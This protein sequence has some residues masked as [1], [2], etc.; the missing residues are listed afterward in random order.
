MSRCDLHLHSKF[1]DRSE[2]WIFRRFDFPD[3]YSDP[4]ELYRRA[5]AAGMDFVTITDHDTIE[6]CLAISRIV[7]I[8]LL[9]SRLR[10][11]FR[12][13]HAKLICSSG[14]F[15]RRNTPRSARLRD[16]IFDLQAF[17]QTES[18]AH[19]VAHPLYSINGKLSTSH[20][21]RLI[22]L[23][24]HFEG[25][26]R[27]AR[28]A[29]ER[30]HRSTFLPSSRRE[31]IAEF[32][33]RHD[34]R[35]PIPSR[36]KKSSSAART[37]TAGSLLAQPSPKR[38]PRERRTIFSTTSGP[39]AAARTAKGGTP[40]ALS[41]GFYNTLSLFHPGPLHREARTERRPGGKNVFAFHGGA[42]PDRV[43]PRG[44]SRLHHAGR[45]FRQNLR[46]RET[47]EH[48]A[49]ARALELLR[50]AGSESED[51]RAKSRRSPNPSVAR[52]SWPT[53]PASS[54]PF[55][56]SKNSCSKSAPAT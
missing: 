32:A 44:K 21:E 36:G 5:K 46:A 8:L 33:E 40:L 10:L 6:G 38:Q 50:A 9:A 47:G 54:S 48:F 34:S 43:H 35:R 18:I 15:R 45:P 28:R 56:S 55:A 29:A 16:N 24:Q 25:R 27:S 31:K 49:L 37:I 4:R 14:D 12:K 20:L 42:R 2:D 51:S 19:A 23:F 7:A 3:S 53:P 17:L 41:H 26:Q 39:A 13:I 11:I 1:S 30:P 22:L 52:S